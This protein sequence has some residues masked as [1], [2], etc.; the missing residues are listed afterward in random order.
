MQKSQG[1]K[2]RNATMIGALLMT[3]QL[4]EASAETATA[5]LPV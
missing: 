1:R 2:W 3:C 5:C 4:A